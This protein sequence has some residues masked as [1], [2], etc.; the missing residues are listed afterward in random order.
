MLPIILFAPLFLFLPKLIRTKSYGI[1]KFGNLIRKHNIAYA[2]KW[3]EGKGIETEELLGSV[4]NSSLADINGSYGPVHEMQL[5]P[6]NLKMLI[7]SF[8]MNLIPYLP[9]IFTYYTISDLFND[10]LK[11]IIGT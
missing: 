3:I 7:M 10:F 11:T 4:D 5:S 2:E 8:I 9:L 1:Q 6:I